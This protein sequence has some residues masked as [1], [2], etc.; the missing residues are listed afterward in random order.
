MTIA[1]NM[2]VS[3]KVAVYSYVYKMVLIDA[4]NG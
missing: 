1:V 2:M 4:L 3:T